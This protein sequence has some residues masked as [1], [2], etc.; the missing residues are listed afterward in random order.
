[1]FTVGTGVIRRIIEGVP[2]GTG[3][4]NVKGSKWTY[5]TNDTAAAVEGAGFFNS[6]STQL[7]AGDQIDASLDLDGTP[8][9]KDYLVSAIAAGV[10]TIVAAAA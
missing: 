7:R 1:M 3:P 9:R 5:V 8:A 6:I 10:V 4:D 2:L